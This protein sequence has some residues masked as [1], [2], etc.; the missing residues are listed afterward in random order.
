MLVHKVKLTDDQQNTIKMICTQM[1]PI[2]WR[3][4]QENKQD[5]SDNLS[6]I[7]KYID[8]GLVDDQTD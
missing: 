5:M 8:A 2:V 3:Y 4:V 7:E 1:K 6:Y